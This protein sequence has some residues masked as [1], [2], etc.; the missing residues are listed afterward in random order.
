V[1][2]HMVTD[3]ART[4][5]SEHEDIPQPAATPFG[6]EAAEPVV[7]PARSRSRLRVL[8]GLRLLAALAVLFYHYTAT[9]DGYWHPAGVRQFRLLRHLSAYGWLGVNL[10]FLI[11][12]FVICMSSWNRGLGDFFVSRVARLYPAY[13]VGIAFTTVVV[14]TFPTPGIPRL[15]IPDLLA[16]LTMMQTGLDVPNADGPYWTLWRE[17]LFYMT[18]AIVIWRGVN[19]RRAVT[20][21]LAWTIISVLTTA[22][23]DPTLH[24]V[25]DAEYSMFFV[26]GVAMYLIYRFGCNAL[27]LGIVGFSWILAVHQASVLVPLIA[28][29]TSILLSVVVAII[30]MSFGVVLAAA[31]GWFD[32]VQWRWL[33]TAGALTYP[34]YLIHGYAGAA[35]TYHFSPHVP[36]YVLLIG[37]VVGMVAAAWLIH[38]AFERPFERALKR[39][40]V[41]AVGD[42]RGHSVPGR[43]IQPGAAPSQG[44]DCAAAGLRDA[45]TGAAIA[46]RKAAE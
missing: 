30:T 24:M 21:C 18:F 28:K 34:L 31:L 8:D 25:V 27:L 19:Y 10:F 46:A 43:P 7:E 5:G 15:N 26:A 32:N 33:T 37:L 39:V 6:N 45:G 4:V 9:S 3:A 35:L 14:R 41:R 1:S 29:E 13:F 42:L 16:N 12:G 2:P 40:L 44:V 20:F 36:R 17:L 22:S 23:K 38:V 11:S